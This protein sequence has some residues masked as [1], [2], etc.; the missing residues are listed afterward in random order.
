MQIPDELIDQL[1]GEILK[2]LEEEAKA[3][4]RKITFDDLEGSTFRIRQKIGQQLLQKTADT[5]DSGKL[6][7]KT[8]QNAGNRSS[9]KATKKRK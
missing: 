2:E 8:A 5:L 1:A 6:E 9:T 4:N 3:A 7:K